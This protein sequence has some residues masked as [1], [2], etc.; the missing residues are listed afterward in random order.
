MIRRPPRSTLFSYT[1]LFRSLVGSHAEAAAPLQHVVDLVLVG[2]AVRLLGLAW[3]HAVEVELGARRRGEPDLR[4]LVGLELHVVL[5][6]DTHRP[7][8]PATLRDGRR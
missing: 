3:R 5:N 4:H 1:T 2:V 7:P 6:P 8:S